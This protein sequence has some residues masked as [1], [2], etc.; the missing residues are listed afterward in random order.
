MT[1]RKYSGRPPKADRVW[2]RDAIRLAEEHAADHGKLKGPHS[3][4]GRKPTRAVAATPGR[5]LTRSRGRQGAG[6]KCGL[7]R[8]LLWDWFVDARA[9]I[10]SQ[11]SPKFVIMKGRELAAKVLAAQRLSGCYTPLPVIDKHW[12]LRWKRDKGVVF[13]KPNCRYKCSRAVMKARLRAMWLNNIRIRAL[14]DRLRGKNLADQIYGIDEKPLHFNES[15]SKCRGTLEVAGAEYVKL[16]QNHAATRER[17]S[18]MTCISSKV[19]AA[20][21]PQLLPVRS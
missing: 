8:E 1:Y 7:I 2:L 3:H 21:Q 4:G 9:S 6:Y 13:R 17:C 5:F 12:L 11:L 10:A 18:L 14:C 16:K 15:G 20:T 19:A